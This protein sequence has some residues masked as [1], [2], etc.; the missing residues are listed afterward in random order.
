MN[1]ERS[2]RHLLMTAGLW[3]ATLALALPAWA[4]TPA[5]AVFV[6]VDDAARALNQGATLL[7]ARSAAEH[8][9]GH[10]MGAINAPWQDFSDP[11]SLGRLLPDIERLRAR[12]EATGV[13]GDRPVYVLGGWDDAWGEEG[14]IFWMLDVLG[15]PDTHIVSGGYE[16]WV[17][18]GFPVVGGQGIPVM[19]GDFEPR[20]PLDG[21]VT[22]DQIDAQAIILDVR[23]REEFD[24]ATPYGSERGGHIPG[25]EHI[26]WHDV[27]DSAGN[28]RD[29]AE[30]RTLLR[31]DM[32][33]VTAY[34]T[35]GV[36]SGFI[37]AIL[38]DLGAESPQNYAG[39][40]WEY[41]AT[42]LPVE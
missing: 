8:A 11:E 3:L 30:L 6:S 41:A 19:A 2:L 12:I 22:V 35:G 37:Y 27:F 14:R 15:H 23:T 24:G 38:R 7:D 16:A 9:A 39:S 25:A 13:R 28:L 40:W 29:S 18:A 20:P 5:G 10:P 36:R 42:D 34:C 32:P 26:H 31:A 33:G 1:L 17:S 21:V 4:Q